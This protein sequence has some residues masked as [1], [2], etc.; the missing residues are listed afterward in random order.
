MK[1]LTVQSSLASRHCFPLRFKYS[2]HP[3]LRHHNRFQLKLLLFAYL[4][5]VWFIIRLNINDTFTV[6]TD[7]R[8]VE[9]VQRNFHLNFPLLI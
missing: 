9:N 3:V 8:M 5:V 6:E 2:Q 7:L 1:F 4:S